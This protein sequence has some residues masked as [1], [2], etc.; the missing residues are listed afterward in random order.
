MS[1]YETVVCDYCGHVNE[2]P[3]VPDKWITS[4][5]EHF[6]TQYCAVTYWHYY[7]KDGEYMGSL[8]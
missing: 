6:D 8:T 5:G 3:T 4:N 2:G 1:I 7:N